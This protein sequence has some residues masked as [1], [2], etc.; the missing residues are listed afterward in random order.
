MMRRRVMTQAEPSQ[1]T[2]PPGLCSRSSPRGSRHLAQTSA[3]FA[4][5]RFASS[6]V[7]AYSSVALVERCPSST[8]PAGTGGRRGTMARCPVRYPPCVVCSEQG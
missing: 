3:F 6:V 5:S 1:R 4:A 2:R 8:A 7:K